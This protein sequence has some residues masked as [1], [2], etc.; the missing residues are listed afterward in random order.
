MSNEIKEFTVKRSTWLRGNG[1]GRLLHFGDRCCLGFL[2]EACGYKDDQI[3]DLGVPSECI[4]RYYANLWPETIAADELNTE[5]CNKIIH[6]NDIEICDADNDLF[7]IES[8]TD[9]ER[10]L[11][12]L[13]ADAKIT[14]KFED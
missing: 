10:I 6:A 14:V 7:K 3:H 11:T 4:S 12:G 13:F 5:I 2:A 1:S 9:R 8:D